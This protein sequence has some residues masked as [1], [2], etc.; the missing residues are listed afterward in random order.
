MLWHFLAKN[1]RNALG[2]LLSAVVGNFQMCCIKLGVVLRLAL[3]VA[4]FYRL[5][6]EFFDDVVLENVRNRSHFVV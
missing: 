4:R 1:L 5:D 6:L 3:T 2:S